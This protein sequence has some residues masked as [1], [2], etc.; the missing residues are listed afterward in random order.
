M[1]VLVL[2]A[3]LRIEGRPVLAAV[4]ASDGPGFVLTGLAT[5]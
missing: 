3:L 2:R 4:R 5:G 1:S